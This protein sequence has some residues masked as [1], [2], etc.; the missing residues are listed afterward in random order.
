MMF[1]NTLKQYGRAMLLESE[2]A[3]SPFDQFRVWFDEAT[4]SDEAEPTAMTLA[5]VDQDGQ[6]S[7][8]IVLLKG[9]DDNGFVF[10]TNYLSRKGKDLA[11]HPKAALLF[12]WPR[13][14]RQV[15][16]EGRVE[17]LPE[18]ESDTYYASRP[19]SSRIGAWASEQS[20]EI[21]SREVLEQRLAEFERKFGDNPPRPPHWGGLRLVPSAF[22]FWQGRP[23][24]L[25]DRIVY[26]PAEKGWRIARLA[27]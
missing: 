23:S 22:E 15:R 20:N 14:E 3:A 17:R 10:F 24:R 27:P 12:F 13:L 2:V 11:A 8:R 16:I 7:A 18:A 26:L 6:P 19:V 1:S 25:H 9:M 5:T 21:A 4:R